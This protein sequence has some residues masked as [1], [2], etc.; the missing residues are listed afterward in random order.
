MKL[1]R[2]KSEVLDRFDDIEIKID[3]VKVL[4]KNL[5]NER[6]Q[7]IEDML[8]NMRANKI[9]EY[10][11]QIKKL[12]SQIEDKDLVIDQ[13][14]DAIDKISKQKEEAKAKLN[15]AKQQIKKLEKEIED[16]KSDRYL[17][18]ELKP[19]KVKKQ[20]VMGIKRSQA[21]SGAKAILRKKSEEK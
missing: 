21:G 10:D 15:D 8:V 9:V 19:E 7:R 6:E 14:Q 17:K 16:L 20:K 1:F 3:A 4:I 5:S 11:N 18:V 13:Q 2:K 12:K